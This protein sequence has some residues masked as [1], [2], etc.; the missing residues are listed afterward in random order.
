MPLATPV[1]DKS[2]YDL[3][4]DA[5]VAENYQNVMNTAS[6]GHFKTIREILNF[7]CTHTGAPTTTQQVTLLALDSLLTSVNNGHPIP[8]WARPYWD[9]LRRADRMIFTVSLAGAEK[10]L[11]AYI[12]KHILDTLSDKYERGIETREKVSSRDRDFA[13]LSFIRGKHS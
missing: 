10:A 8:D 12:F 5:V 4:V 9:E 2:Q 13:L 1:Q 6:K 3:L 7:V 11:A